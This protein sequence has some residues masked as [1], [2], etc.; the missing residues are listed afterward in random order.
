LIMSA[1]PRAS[2]QA[3]PGHDTKPPTKPPNKANPSQGKPPHQG[4][5]AMGTQT[6]PQ[7]D[8]IQDRHPGQPRQTKLKLATTPSHSTPQKPAMEAEFLN[9]LEAKLAD[10]KA[11]S[12]DLRRYL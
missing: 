4:K 8:G 7:D 3:K 11:R 2:I 1:I 10:L 9:A 12:E 5:E 6:K